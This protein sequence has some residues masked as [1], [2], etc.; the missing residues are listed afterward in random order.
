MD[1]P[2][3]ANPQCP[4]SQ[5]IIDREEVGKFVTIVCITCNGTQIIT[6]DNYKTG[7]RREVQRRRRLGQGG[8]ER[9]TKYFHG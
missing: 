6:N 1:L 7:I 8:F 5:T 2:K 9:P 4:K 3:C